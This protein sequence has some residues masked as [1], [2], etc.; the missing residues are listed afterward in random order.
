M[1]KNYRYPGIKP[2]TTSDR[3]LFFGRDEDIEKLAQLI[4]LER[5]VVLYGKSGLGKTSLLN[6]GV[7]PKLQDEG[8][9]QPIY[10]RFGS[11]IEGQ[12]AHPLDAV[13]EKSL[14]YQDQHS[15]LQDIHEE[16]QSLWFTFKQLQALE[17]LEKSHL[18]IFDQFEEL[19]TYP[20]EQIKDFKKELADVLNNNLPQDFKTVL[21]LKLKENRSF[22]SDEQM[23]LLYHPPN[24]KIIISIRSDRMSLLD[25]FKDFIPDIL[26]KCYELDALDIEQAK[27][28][29]LNPALAI[30]AF[31]T[32][33]FDYE[34]PA[35]QKILRFLSKD[36][37]QKIESF[38]L[39]ILCQSVEEYVQ[40]SGDLSISANDLGDLGL[41]YKNY[42]DNQIAA[43]GDAPEQRAA[44]LLIEDGLIFE[45]EERRL[46]LYEGQIYRNYDIQPDLLKKLVAARLLRAEPNT[47][48]GYSYELC[49]DTLVAPILRSKKKR[50]EEEQRLA[51]AK[52]NAEAAQ[53]DRE[54]RAKIRKRYLTT[55]GTVAAI[56]VVMFLLF[57]WA[58]NQQRIAKKALE[59][60]EM[61]KAELVLKESALLAA[62]T[63]LEAEKERAEANSR[64]AQKQKEEA[65]RQRE[66]AERRGAEALR[67][68]QDAQRQ[69]NRVELLLAQAQEET[70]RTRELFAESEWLNTNN[71][72]S[73]QFNDAIRE[74]IRLK[75]QDSPEY[76]NA[77][78]GFRLLALSTIEDDIQ[79]RLRMLEKAQKIYPH[80]LTSRGLEQASGNILL[81]EEQG[82]ISSNVGLFAVALSPDKK[83][84]AVASANALN[85]YDANKLTLIG[86]IDL[87]GNQTGLTKK[88]AFSP[89]G[90]KLMSVHKESSLVYVWSAQKPSNQPLFVLQDDTYL[91]SAAFHP[92]TGDILTGSGIAYIKLWSGK[93]G[94]LLREVPFESYGYQGTVED[95]IIPNGGQYYL[96]KTDSYAGLYSLKN[97]DEISYF[98]EATDIAYDPVNDNYYIGKGSYYYSYVEVYGRNKMKIQLNEATFDANARAATKGSFSNS[99]VQQTLTQDAFGLDRGVDLLKTIDTDQG[100]KKI[101][102]SPQSGKLFIAGNNDRFHQLRGGNQSGLSH[103]G[104]FIGHN[105]PVNGAVFLDENTLITAG[106]DGQLLRWKLEKSYST[107]YVL[108]KLPDIDLCDA[109]QRD[110]LRIEELQKL[111]RATRQEAAQCYIKQGDLDKAALLN[112]NDPSLYLKKAG[113]FRRNGDDLAALENYYKALELSPA[114]LNC[115]TELGAYL[116]EL[117]RYE[118]ARDIYS[119]KLAL[120]PENIYC[121]HDLALSYMM[122]GRTDEAISSFKK[123]LE[124]DP[125][126]SN[127]YNGIGATLKQARQFDEALRYLQIANQLDSFNHFPY[128]NMADIYSQKAMYDSSIYY[129]KRSLDVYPG[130]LDGMYGLGYVFFQKG[131]I[132]SAGT[133][134]QKTV[135]LDTTFVGGWNGLGICYSEKGLLPQAHQIFNKAIEIDSTYQYAYYG[136]GYTYQLEDKY[137]EALRYYQKALAIDPSYSGAFEQMIEIYRIEGNDEAI[138]AAYNS[139]LELNGENTNALNNLGIVFYDKRE[140]EE[141]AKYFLKAA[142]VNPNFAIGWANAGLAYS[143]LGRYDEALLYY[144]KALEIDPAYNAHKDIG[145]I[146]FNQKKDYHKALEYYQMGLIHYPSDYDLHYNTGLALNALKRFSE[147]IP[148]FEKA[149]ELSPGNADPWYNI[150]LSYLGLGNETEALTAFVKSFDYGVDLVEAWPNIQKMLDSKPSLA[151]KEALFE[152]IKAISNSGN[153]QLKQALFYVQEGL[154]D[155]AQDIYKGIIN[156][157]PY[158]ETAYSNLANLYVLQQDQKKALAL[159]EDL[160]QQLKVSWANGAWYYSFQTLT[161]LGNNTAALAD[162]SRF[163]ESVIDLL[164]AI[165]DFKKE[166]I[167]AGVELPGNLINDYYNI[168]NVYHGIDKLSQAALNWEEG[169]QYLSQLYAG[170]TTF[171]ARSNLALACGNVSWYQLF[172]K[173]ADKAEQY[174]RE[175]LALDSTRTWIMTNLSSA[176]LMAGKYHEAAQI[177]RSMQGI[178]YDFDQTQYYSQVFMADLEVLT[179]YF[180]RERR[181]DLQRAQAELQA[182]LQEERRLET[183]RD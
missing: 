135:L 122:L 91:T 39:Q 84:L 31:E 77:R 115:Y 125:N 64:E 144:D 128:Y 68:F 29:I 99:N 94:S 96:A 152:Q 172:I 136:K 46:S 107:N 26:Q 15:F 176:L 3:N 67:N 52:A 60:V 111:D 1:E 12:R 100:L 75:Q 2:F 132:D 163:D 167:Q 110:I 158:F 97:G 42:Y 9:H 48:G 62:N 30:G 27:A 143:Q 7:V 180:P 123:V 19:F 116:Y 109:I 54:R 177:Y 78:R 154:Y 20:E 101:A 156:Q 141:A 32:P 164:L 80:P 92:E 138:E 6:A 47:A 134:F 55:L 155:K 22:L 121:H 95:L 34:P 10:F 11:Y 71:L 127:A 142:E 129:Y 119:R 36:N 146:Y 70:E 57:L 161:N 8:G 104:L 33:A 151:E 103:A 53:R 89:D 165:R 13:I 40:S 169:Y 157:D 73:I 37:T 149:F 41:I 63:G 175:G 16:P 74:L 159:Y 108:S 65:E 120:D 49:H 90:S 145:N 160:L 117:R 44:R 124:K 153:I 17:G 28:A 24:V 147:A 105:A 43:L 76:E 38:Q 139:F 114:D 4:A 72:D 162:S 171:T 102:L 88:V 166:A 98:G 66:E 148:Y 61:Q 118:E 81:P 83:T 14:P 131:E 5:L 35:L 45:P 182:I 79:M 178:R 51:E 87:K 173:N 93:D 18:L 85:L 150:G 112:P 126:N 113:D 106:S 58:L 183:E 140:Y 23:R 69:R 86:S 174:A 25:K 179:P 137:E 82:N 21:R 168:G 59:E 56:A 50:V 181:E 170:D 133:L 130:Y